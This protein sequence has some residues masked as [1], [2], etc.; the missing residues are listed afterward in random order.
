MRL[1]PSWSLYK[2]DPVYVAQIQNLLDSAKA[3]VG[4]VSLSV[5]L[6]GAEVR[7]DDVI[8]GLSPFEGALFVEPGKHAIEAQRYGHRTAR[9]TIDAAPGS[10]HTIALV[11]VPIESPPNAC[12]A[13]APPTLTFLTDTRALDESSD[14]ADLLAK[15]GDE[16]FDQ[17]RVE[18]AEALYRQSWA[19]KQSYHVA[20]NLGSAEMVLGKPQ[21]A[22]EH[23]LLALKHVP[24]FVHP[25][26]RTRAH[27]MLAAARAQIGSLV[28]DVDAVGSEVFVDGRSVGTSPLA[29]EVFVDPGVH[30]VQASHT[31][32]APASV[33]VHVDKG[34]TWKV[35]LPLAPESKSAPPR[36]TVLL[37]TIE[38]SI[39]PWIA[40]V[41]MGLFAGL[42]GVIGLRRVESVVVDT[43]GVPWARLRQPHKR[44]LAKQ[45]RRL[46]R[47]ERRLRDLARAR[48]ERRTS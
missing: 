16:H 34:T 46:A 1:Y 26:S 25:E 7:V 19:L 45:H 15:Q 8:V 11:L 17:G 18:E 35:R 32:C 40:V 39:V 28:I 29:D 5:N 27:E 37:L 14:R 23:L 36:A 33:A 21:A 12:A 22:A 30:V 3:H 43:N 31:G 44:R 6:D 47:A 4:A 41:A 24:S 2:P 9:Q 10:S 20:G 13:N 42:G 48:A 38:P